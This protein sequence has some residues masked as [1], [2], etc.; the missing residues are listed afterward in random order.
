MSFLEKEFDKDLVAKLREKYEESI[1]EVFELQQDNVLK[2]IDY[3]KDI[4]IEH[5]DELIIYKLELFTIN[6]DTIIKTFHEYEHLPEIVDL[7]NE[8]ITNID[9]I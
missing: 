7:I 3:L 8:D 1:L 9:N 2:V 5:I 4:G 6:I